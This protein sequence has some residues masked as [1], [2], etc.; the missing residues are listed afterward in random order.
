MLVIIA[1]AD[2]TNNVREIRF[3]VLRKLIAILAVHEL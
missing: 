3:P 2:C 1:F